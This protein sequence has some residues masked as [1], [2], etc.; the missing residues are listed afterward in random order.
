APPD[1]IEKTSRDLVASAAGKLLPDQALPELEKSKG[2]PKDSA[3]KKVQP[4]TPSFSPPA[5]EVPPPVTPPAGNSG[6]EQV[7]TDASKTEE[8]QK[9]V[10]QPATQSQTASPQQLTLKDAGPV[11]KGAVPEKM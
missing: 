10:D 7:K 8:A 4:R 5:P 6:A 11:Q 1:E 2:Y 3:D 9:K